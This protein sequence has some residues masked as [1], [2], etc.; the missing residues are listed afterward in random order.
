MSTD[1]T[2]YLKQVS[3]FA[4]LP[5]DDLRELMAVAKK[6]IFR[7]GEVIFHRDDP[8]QV[9]YIIKEGKVKIAI[10]S[11]D[12]QEISLV[13]FGKGEY[14]GEFALL[15][16][17]PRSADAVALERVE[18]YTLQRDDFHRAILK[19][20]RIAIHMLESLSRR[21]RNTDRM[22]EDLI[23][24]DVP[25]RVAKKL[26]ELAELHGVPTEN[27]VRIDIRLTQQDLAAMVGASRESVNKV[28][29]YFS[30]KGY[31]STGHHRITLRRP[32]ELKERIY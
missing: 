29:G 20:P 17:L 15:D 19:N 13:I 16:G 23:F 5:D 22:I 12:G 9:L 7:P 24:L 27:G 2:L 26:L 1:E 8:G 6:R 21:L 31:I 18:C 30:A 25:G 14:F 4:E 28:L 10:N 3:S 32:A 11:P